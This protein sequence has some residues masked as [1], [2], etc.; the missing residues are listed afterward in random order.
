MNL[1]ITF[2]RV[3]NFILKFKLQMKANQNLELI[4]CF[5][6]NVSFDDSPNFDG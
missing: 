6:N 3:V 2:Q 1:S 5:S 4:G